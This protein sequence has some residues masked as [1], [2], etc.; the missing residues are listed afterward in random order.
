[1]NTITIRDFLLS[2]LNCK[3]FIMHYIF[4][5]F[6]QGP[7]YFPTSHPSLPTDEILE[8]PLLYKSMLDLA[9]TLDVRGLFAEPGD[10]DTSN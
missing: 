8:H 2:E 3:L 5:I 1:M 10:G 6:F 9:N 4:K 7:S